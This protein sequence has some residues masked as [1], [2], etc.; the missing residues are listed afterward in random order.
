MVFCSS[1]ML[2]KFSSHESNF[3]SRVVGCLFLFPFLI[4]QIRVGPRQGCY[5][6]LF[7][8]RVACLYILLINTA[9]NQQ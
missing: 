2:E 8:V 5:F 9:K 1:Q 6:N 3:D 7:L 4:S